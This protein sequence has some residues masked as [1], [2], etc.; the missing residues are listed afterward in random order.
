MGTDL[1]LT[2]NF[3]HVFSSFLTVGALDAFQQVLINVF[4]ISSENFVEDGASIGL[5]SRSCLS[6]L[7]RHLIL[8]GNLSLLAFFFMVP[9]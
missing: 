8:Y 7:Y 5:V 2:K 1:F 4:S 3:F 9:F 6:P